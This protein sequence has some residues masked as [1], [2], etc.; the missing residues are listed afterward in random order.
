[1]CPEGRD[2]DVDD[3][4]DKDQGGGRIVELIESP[5]PFYL[6]KVQSSCGE[7]GEANEGLGG[8]GTARPGG[9]SL[10]LP[11]PQPLRDQEL[12]G[13]QCVEM[14]SPSLTKW[15]VH[16]THTHVGSVLNRADF[17]N[18]HWVFSEWGMHALRNA[19]TSLSSHLPGIVLAT[20]RDARR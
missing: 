2:E 17:G 18:L 5:L 13:G 4:S 7:E 6:I 9:D 15:G 3:D 8:G 11:P 10:E 1:M 12:V 20:R 16:A 19:A 14:P